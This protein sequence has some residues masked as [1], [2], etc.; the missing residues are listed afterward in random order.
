MASFASATDSPCSPS[1]RSSS[2]LKVNSEGTAGE[3]R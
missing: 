1:M 3:V 2:I